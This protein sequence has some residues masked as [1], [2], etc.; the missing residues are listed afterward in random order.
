MMDSRLEQAIHSGGCGFCKRLGHHVARRHFHELAL[1]TGEG[2][3]HQHADG[4]AHAFQLHVLFLGL[5]DVESAQLGFRCARAGAKLDAAVAQQIERGNA[6]GDARR[7]I[8]IRRRLHDAVSDANVLG[9][10]AHRGEK[11]FGRRGVRVFFQEV[12]LGGPDIVVSALIGQDGLFQRVLEQR[13]LGIADP[14][15]GE[16]M[17]VKTAKFHE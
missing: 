11:H 14:G 7:V 4:H 10:L 16:L 5:R 9:A 8:N 1:V 15:P 2:I 17:F 13:M 3:F 12:M 6:L